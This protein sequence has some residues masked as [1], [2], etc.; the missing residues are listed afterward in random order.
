[1][2]PNPHSQS[3][4]ILGRSF[5]IT[6]NG[7]CVS[8]LL[9][10]L[11]TTVSIQ[12]GKKLSYAL[13]MRTDYEETQNLKKYSVKDCPYH[14]NKDEFLKRMN[15]LKSI[16]KLFS[17]KSNPD[18]GLSSCSK[19]WERP[20]SYELES[21]KPVLPK[22]EHLK[23]KIGEGDFE[24]LREVLNRNADIFSRHKADI[25]CCNF[26]EHEIELE[27]GAVPLRE[28]ARQMTP[29][30]SE[31]CR[32]EIDMLLE[33]DMIEPPKFPWACGVV[34]AKSKG[35][36]RFCCDFCYLNAVTIKDAYPIPRID[37]S[38]SKLGDAKFFT[39]LDLGS[40][41]W[42]VPLRKKDRKKTGFACELGLYQSDKEI[43]ESCDVLR[44]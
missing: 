4:V 2:V 35:Q 23:G 37:E 34:M 9:N 39:A 5:S 26:I 14:A 10:T 16:H 21:D 36:L 17:M 8:V 28:G 1:M 3:S 13:P 44:R 41:F 42:Q 22:I 25:G 43:R 15:E 24:L 32:A 31:A 12:R 11:D 30:K 29:Q 33:Y 7:L 19:F 18:D 27:E 40:A 20:S 6:R 38:L